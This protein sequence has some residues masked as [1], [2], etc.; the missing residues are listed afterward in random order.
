MTMPCSCKAVVVLDLDNTLYKEMYYPISGYRAIAHYITHIDAEAAKIYEQMLLWY[1]EGQNVFQL[2]SETY[3]DN[4]DIATCLHVY[5]THKPKV[6]L[7][8]G[9]H[10]VLQRLKE[11]GC[12]LCIITDG[13]SIT[14][15]NKIEALGLQEFFKVDDIIIS[16]EFGGEKPSEG[17]YRYF[18]DK[19]PNAHYTYVADNTTKDFITPNKL[20]WST[21]WLLDNGR[22]IHKQRFDLDEIYLLQK[23]IREIEELT[24]YIVA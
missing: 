21:I 1:Q 3:P 13:R 23:K 12:L 9:C 18:M 22:N 8:D 11:H 24:N 2:L 10:E 6:M 15:R 20:G 16:E 14:H 5:R 17:N 19:Y 7:S 4:I